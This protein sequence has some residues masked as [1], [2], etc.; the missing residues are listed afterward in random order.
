MDKRR[1][2][3]TLPLE[4]A[5]GVPFEPGLLAREETRRDDAHDVL[6]VRHG[7]AVDGHDRVI[8]D[9]DPEPVE[10]RDPGAGLQLRLEMAGRSV[11]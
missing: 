1:R 2:P 4:E 7:D 10:G 5:F 6:R 9:M 3:S 8:A 11:K